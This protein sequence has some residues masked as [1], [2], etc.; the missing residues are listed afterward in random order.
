MRIHLKHIVRTGW[1]AAL[2]AA[3]WQAAAAD[4]EKSGEKAQQ[5]QPLPGVA[6]ARVRARLLYEALQG[7]LMVM[8][9]DFFNR[10]E[11]K[12]VPSEAMRDIF[13]ALEEQWGVRLRWI[14]ADE[15]LMN[16]DNKAR[17]EFETKA[18][19]ALEG[20]ALEQEAVEAGRY[21][22]AGTITL[23]NQCLKC[24]TPNRKS[25]EDRH[26]GLSISMPVDPAKTP[27]PAKK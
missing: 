4:A 7:S 27:D 9:R 18:L 13:K 25:L 1:A 26:A 11:H 20:G 12:V 6:E 10:H 15:T 5:T 19:V 22:F 2:L 16:G 24:H 21:R 23:Q 14:A 3:V 8:H 17:D